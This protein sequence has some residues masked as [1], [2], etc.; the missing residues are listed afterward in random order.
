MT[1]V[2]VMTRGCVIICESSHKSISGIFISILLLPLHK[3]LYLPFHKSAPLY[4]KSA[5]PINYFICPSIHQ[6]LP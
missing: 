4:H 2:C 5:P 1:R 6:P 3:L